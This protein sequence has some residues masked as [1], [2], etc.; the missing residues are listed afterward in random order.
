MAPK[1]ESLNSGSSVRTTE[2]SHLF[3]GLLPTPLPLPVIYPRHV[4]GLFVHGQDFA[5]QNVPPK[6]R[7]SMDIYICHFISSR[8]VLCFA[9]SVFHRDKLWFWVTTL[10][11]PYD[12]VRRH[13]YHL[14]FYSRG[15]LIF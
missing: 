3:L 6:H 1:L 4:Y 13:L 14:C 11:T 10:T 2:Q 12:D 8:S 7:S 15:K 5:R 9:L